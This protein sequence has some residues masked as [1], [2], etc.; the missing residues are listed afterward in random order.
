[1]LK[2]IK[3]K[4]QDSSPNILD[5]QKAMAKKRLRVVKES[6]T[7]DAPKQTQPPTSTK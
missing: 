1:M 4:R 2:I 7:K 6:N 5:F 3:G